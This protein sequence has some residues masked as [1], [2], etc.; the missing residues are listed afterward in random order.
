MKRYLYIILSLL[1]FGQ[2]G[3]AQSA[4]K[5]MQDAYQLGLSRATG[6]MLVD[7]AL[8]EDVW[9]NADTATDFWQ[10]FPQDGLPAGRQTVVRMAYDDRFLYISAECYDTN[11]YVVQTLK[12]DSRFF[13]G[14]AFGLV[15][16]PVNRR[17]NGFLFGVSPMNVQSEDLISAS[18]FG[19]LNFSWDNK[20]F[21][22]VQRHDDRWVVEMA[23]PFKTLRFEAG[24]DTWGINFFRY[25][26][27]RNEVSS[28]T[29]MPVNFDVQ[30]LGYTG[31]LHWDRSPAKPGANVSLIPYLSGSLYRNNEV[32]DP[33]D[34]TRFDGGF[35][36]KVALT[37]SLN[38]DLTV[39]P[40][41]S[42][43]DVD[44]QQTNLTRFSLQFPERRPFFLENADLFADFGTPPARPI[45]TR[46]IGL[47]ENALPIRILYGARLS[48][49]I[50]N[51]SRIGLLNLQT[52][53]TDDR[54]AHNYS[55]LSFN[56]SV[57]KRSLIKGYVTNRQAYLPG[58]GFNGNDYGRNAGLEFNYRNL[59]GTW[60]PWVAIHV[61]DKS[62]VG[63]STFRNAGVRYSGRNLSYFIDYIGI[64]TNYYADMGFIPRL[65]NYDAARDTVIRL[66][67]E[68]IF[69][70]LGYT[71]RPQ[72]DGAFIAHEFTT[73]S[74]FIFNPDWTL[75]ERRSTLDYSALF[76]N[77]GEFSFSVENYDNRLLFASRFTEG[78]PLPPARYEYTQ[79]IAGY[80]SDARKAFA[81]EAEMQGGQFYNGKLFRYLAGI[82][83]R[84]QPW[85]NFSIAFEQNDLRLPE[86]YGDNK[87]SLINQR[88]EIN[89][90]NQLF[91]TTFLQ[92]NTQ[93]N[94]F[95]VNS[96]L[97]WRYQPMS[98]F[99]LVYTDNYFSDPFLQHKNR[100]I[101]FKW[102]YWLTL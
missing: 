16:D 19:D 17:S 14:D 62:G 47:D 57:L 95:N 32:E 61:S 71:I 37:S 55:I 43:I 49:N 24:K 77:T 5:D 51:N 21:S 65:E 85:G 11:Y 72:G 26:L 41:F 8:T 73:S 42:Q 79:F 81:L 94:N 56:Q 44:I 97:Q 3:K 25:D 52:R 33:A 76:R 74:R 39:N 66:G 28:W 31:A 30:D 80:K 92:Y 67:F 13:E 53:A 50:G 35:D 96:R 63:T 38:L 82:I 45:F 84:A 88:T 4:G 6:E 91:W 1:L 18:Q 68:H 69:N 22:A 87:L 54:D 83:Y 40:D 100:A 2:W 46:S 98:D 60:N 90:S 99:F 23:I 86:P 93:R 29:E 34:E 20:W 102:N 15:L 9:R 75:N 7:G 36:A 70:R 10:K 101:V 27:K 64:G 78:P 12:R 59:S 89:F 48:G 58:E